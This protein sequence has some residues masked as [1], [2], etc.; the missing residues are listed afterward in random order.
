MRE[1]II[2]FLIC[3]LLIFST[4]SLALTPFK[5][6]EVEMKHCFFDTTAVPLTASNRWNKTFGGPDYDEGYSVEQTTDGGYIIVGKTGSFYACCDVW[7]I[8]TDINGY[9]VWDRT[10]GETGDDGG[11]SVQQTSDGGYIIIGETFSYGT[12][13]Y[14][15]WLIKTDGNG[16]KVWDKTFGGTVDDCGNSVQQTSDGGYIIIGETCS[17]GTGSYDVWLIKTDGNGNNVWDR[18]FGGADFD[19]GISVQQTSDGGYIITGE[20]N[21][22]GAG[23]WDIWLIKTDGNGNNVWDKTFGGTGHDVACSVEQTTD[24]GYIIAGTTGSFG[25]CNSDIWL[26]KTDFI[27]NEIWKRT[28][29]GASWDNCRFVQQT[30]DDGYIITGVTNSYGA[31]NSDIWLIKTDGNGIK[32]WDKTFGGT[33]DDWGNSVQQTIDDGYIITGGTYSFGA[34]YV[35][36]WLIKTDSQGKAKYEPPGKPI[37]TGQSGGIIGSEYQYFLISI[38]P[39][40]YNI[41]YCIDWGDNTSEAF[42]GPYPSGVQASAKH[43]W[44]EQGDYTIKAKA[45]NAHG[46]ESDWATLYVSMPKTHIQSP[47]IELIMKIF[48]RFPFLE[49]ILNEIM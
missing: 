46:A 45:R 6:D 48:Q 7:L 44:Y 39:E 23:G 41:T 37:I 10:F 12:G 32:V 5:R 20:T 14:D 9:K 4:T 43:A 21:S 1:K 11:Y 8:K 13:S 49:K 31:G 35:D 24:G 34:G 47:I 18:K 40:G 26:I 29:G 28:F 25:A 42:I 33:N 16:N 17:Y 27:G 2:A 38:D 22:F 15:V 3:V 30:I 36:V 19:Y